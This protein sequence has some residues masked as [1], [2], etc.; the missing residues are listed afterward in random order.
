[1]KK[2]WSEWPLLFVF[3]KIIS[4]DCA[5]VGGV[6]LKVSRPFTKPLSRLRRRCLAAARSKFYSNLGSMWASTPTDCAFIELCRRIST[7]TKCTLSNFVARCNTNIVPRKSDKFKL[8]H[9]KTFLP[10]MLKLTHSHGRYVPI[11]RHVFRP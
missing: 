3:I 1:M 4:A 9:R 10:P 5:E 8:W 6:N 2:Q 11:C 7:T